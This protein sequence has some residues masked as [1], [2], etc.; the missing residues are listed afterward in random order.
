MHATTVQLTITVEHQEG[1]EA[2]DDDVTY[3][4]AEE[5][6]AHG[7]FMV[8]PEARPGSW[9]RIASVERD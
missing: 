5:V 8:D 9:Y 6:G 4:L 2:A 1:P 3:A 7:P